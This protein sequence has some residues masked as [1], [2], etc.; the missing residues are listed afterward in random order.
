MQVCITP[1]HSSRRTTGSN[2]F[3]CLLC[4]K[5]QAFRPLVLYKVY[6][7]EFSTQDGMWEGDQL[8]TPEW[9]KYSTT[10]PPRNLNYAAG[11]WT[12]TYSGLLP[13]RTS[14]AQQMT[15][16]NVCS[17]YCQLP[18]RNPFPQGKFPCFLNAGGA[19]GLAGE[20]AVASHFAAAS[21]E[22][23]VQTS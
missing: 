16:S 11:W 8:L 7:V 17:V 5:P 14:I 15:H 12:D 1:R 18:V 2:L 9:I 20:C 23:L 4:Q 19:L 13:P 6:A 22:A 21:T 3:E 10:V